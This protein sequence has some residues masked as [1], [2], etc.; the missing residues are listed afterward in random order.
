MATQDFTL[1]QQLRVEAIQI[2]LVDELHTV[3]A[4]LKG[5]MAM[6]QESHNDLYRIIHD[7][8]QKLDRITDT[9]DSMD[10]ENAGLVTPGGR[11]E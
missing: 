6:C 8:D 7:A 2:A 9:L 4:L 3:R 10:L 5:G 1:Q 11:H